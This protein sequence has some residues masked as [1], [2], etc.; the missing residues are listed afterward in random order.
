MLLFKTTIV[1]K[2]STKITSKRQSHF[3][4]FFLTA[5]MKFFDTLIKLDHLSSSIRFNLLFFIFLFDSFVKFL[6][7]L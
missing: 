1:V 2:E 3:H 5:A 6:Q 7:I 4:M